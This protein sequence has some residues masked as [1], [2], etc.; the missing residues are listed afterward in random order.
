MPTDTNCPTCRAKRRPA[1]KQV[2]LLIIVFFLI[3][4]GAGFLTTLTTSHWS[5]SEEV[6]STFLYEHDKTREQFT[7]PTPFIV[8]EREEPRDLTEM[9]DEAQSCVYTI[10]T[11]NEQGS[12]FL[13]NEHG[14]VV[15]NAHVI[16]GNS[17]AL[18]TTNEGNEYVAMVEG[19]S[20]HLDIAVLYV[21]ELEGIEPFPIDEHNIF[22]PGEEVIALGSPNGVSN[23]ATIGEIT[24]SERDLVIG[25]YTY[26]DMYEMTASIQ[27]GNSGGP[28]LSKNAETFIGINAAKNV[29]NPSIAYSVPLY[30]VRDII[31]DIITY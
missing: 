6:V 13:Y 30:K 29:N 11:H 26:E 14:F 28:L 27:E 21:E 24:H 8:K 5:S 23:S 16:D 7:F 18:I 31:D 10:V 17:T 20:E 19:F 25:P 2:Y 22:P 3:G 9:I 4:I 1:R 12:G 15:T